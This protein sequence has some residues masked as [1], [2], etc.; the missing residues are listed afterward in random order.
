MDS[1]KVAECMTRFSL[2]LFRAAFL[3]MTE[4]VD[5]HIL[6]KYDVHQKLGRG[7]YGV[8]RNIEIFNHKL[9]QRPL[10]SVV[11]YFAHE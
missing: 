11:P 7:A 1:K 9:M 8:V 5:R 10:Y 6:R 2:F 4:E 3:G